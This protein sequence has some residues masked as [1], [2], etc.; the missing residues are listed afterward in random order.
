MTHIQRLRILPGAVS[1]ISP[2]DVNKRALVFLLCGFELLL[3]DETVFCSIRHM[4]TLSHTTTT[5]TLKP[6]SQLLVRPLI[7]FIAIHF[8]ER[9]DHFCPFGLTN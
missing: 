6:L 1:V 4:H 8:K 3:A 2:P 5:Y 9:G 7:S